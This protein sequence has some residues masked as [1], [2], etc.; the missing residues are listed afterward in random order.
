MLIL[1]VLSS[2]TTR[3]PKNI[4]T[5]STSHRV[6]SS[7][8]SLHWSRV[9]HTI[10]QDVWRRVAIRHPGKEFG[11]RLIRR[12]IMTEIIKMAQKNR[13]SSTALRF[14]AMMLLMWN[15]QLSASTVTWTG[16]G[17]N[18][19]WT[20]VGNWTCNSGACTGPMATALA[21]ADVTFPGGLT[22][23]KL[24]PLDN[25]TVSLDSLT[26]S[27]SE[28]TT[29]QVNPGFTLTI[30]N[31][32]SNSSFDLT[33]SGPTVSVIS[34]S[35]SI[36]VTGGTLTNMSE[37]DMNSTGSLSLSGTAIVNNAGGIINNAF[38]GS[39]II[40]STSTIQNGTLVGAVTN[41]GT[42]NSATFSGAIING[43]VLTGTSTTD[44]TTNTFGATTP[45]TNTGNLSAGAGGTVNWMGGTNSGTLGSGSGTLTVSGT[46]ANAGGTINGG[47]GGTTVTATVNGGTITG[48]VAGTGGTFNN[49]LFTGASLTDGT[50][51]G[52]TNTATG[53]NSFGGF[54][55]NTGSTLSIDSGLS[56]IA[57][58]GEVFGTG[59]T[60]V[61]GG[62]LDI[63]A[64]GEMT[65]GGVLNETSGVVTLS[66]TLAVSATNLL[67]GTFDGTGS[68]GGG[69]V[70]NDGV[71]LNVNGSATAWGGTATLGDYDFTNYAQGASGTLSINFDATSNDQL[72]DA[73][74]TTLAGALDLLNL[75][76]S[77]LSF[78][79]LAD[80][81]YVLIADTN[82]AVLGTF[83]ALNV[84]LPTGW[85]LV[86]NG[87][88]TPTGDLGDVELDFTPGPST[89]EPATDVLLGAAIV[90]I[91][92]MRKKLVRP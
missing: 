29:F 3:L 7:K 43:G 60:T 33:G 36:S 54:V 81:S 87:A 6:L 62:T 39:F 5:A 42:I 25:T 84:A 9:L 80:T 69:T 47:T 41:N 2:K 30:S 31:T 24:G 68:F 22:S 35:G 72:V 79:S 61:S 92:L 85:S 89:P 14:T 51:T 28:Y 91:G 32:T 59:T 37:I 45:V 15:L 78:G 70:T 66:G 74:D 64:G 56:T 1:T 26:I 44:A 48:T 34:N 63:A 90:G 46:L 10:N 20:T 82:S 65:G 19:S 83:G 8:Y 77:A 13:W 21:G 11:Q 53:T 18:D 23:A 17:A 49:V 12:Q 52:T 76:G 67:G 75:D 4:V 58:G 40:G 57:A 71:D 86:Y 16:S 38:G 88:N 55:T 27:G 73:T 50:I